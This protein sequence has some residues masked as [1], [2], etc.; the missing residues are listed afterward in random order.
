M[1]CGVCVYLVHI[2][3]VH[4]VQGCTYPF[5]N[6]SGIICEL[7]MTESAILVVVTEAS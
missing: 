2:C 4:V 3:G 6:L 1:R 7:S 5:N